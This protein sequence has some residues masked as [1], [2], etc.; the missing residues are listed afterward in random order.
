MKK[1]TIGIVTVSAVLLISSVSAFDFPWSPSPEQNYQK[2]QERYQA[3]ITEVREA[4]SDMHSKR[5]DLAYYKATEA[6][7]NKDAKEIARLSEVALEMSVLIEK[8]TTYGVSIT[9]NDEVL[10]LN[11]NQ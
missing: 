4:M 11:P 7:N 2:A 9:V 10:D 3:A 6:A 5:A 8:I 1:T